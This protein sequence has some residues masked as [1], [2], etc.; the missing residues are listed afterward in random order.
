MSEMH[1]HCTSTHGILQCNS[2]TP[3]R[4]QEGVTGALAASGFLEPLAKAVSAQSALSL[5]TQLLSS[6]LAQACSESQQP[7]RHY[8]N[9]ASTPL[10]SDLQGLKHTQ[11]LHAGCR[12][13]RDALAVA[14]C[15][16]WQVTGALLLSTP[17][18]GLKVCTCVMRYMADLLP[19]HWPA[20]VS[21]K[22]LGKPA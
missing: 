7:V 22:K 4:R 8:S 10:G 2:C 1:K 18:S 14:C 11:Q 9:A 5:L 3:M 21:M 16:T 20:G 12:L 17:W 19:V 6:G 15:H 13:R